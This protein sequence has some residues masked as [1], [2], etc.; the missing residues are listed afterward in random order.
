MSKRKQKRFDLRKRIDGKIARWE[1]RRASELG[2]VPL[3]EVQEN[4][5]RDYL[6]PVITGVFNNRREVF[7]K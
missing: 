2:F 4:P 1:L 5:A 3:D 6:V 7:A